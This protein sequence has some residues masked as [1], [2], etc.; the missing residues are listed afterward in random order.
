MTLGGDGA[1]SAAIGEGKMLPA[2]QFRIYA[3]RMAVEHVKKQ[4][5]AMC[6]TSGCLSSDR[7]RAPVQAHWL[8]CHI[9]FLL[10][11]SC[12]AVPATAKAS[13]FQPRLLCLFSFARPSFARTRQDAICVATALVR[14]GVFFADHCN[15][16]DGE[17]RY[18][19]SEDSFTAAASAALRCVAFC[20]AW[21]QRARWHFVCGSQNRHTCRQLCCM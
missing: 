21:T 9:R 5:A 6:P 8:S 1:D 14:A 2:A 20:N 13:L 18:F 3:G 17:T 11:V 19:L 4:Y 7:V 15:F 12:R 10:H 16:V